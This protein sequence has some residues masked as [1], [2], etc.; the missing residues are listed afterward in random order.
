[1]LKKSI[2]VLSGLYLSLVTT[3]QQPPMADHIPVYPTG[4]FRNP[5]NIPIL[6]AGNFGEC[7][8]N[9]FH[10]GIDIKTGGKENL[11]VF[12]AAEGHVSR[13]RMSKGGFGHALYLD[14]PQGFTTV[15]AHLNDF[16]PTIQDYTIKKQYEQENWDIDI[17]LSPEQF[18]V[19]KGQQIAWSGNT[20]SSQ[21]PHLH[22]EI[23]DSRTEHPL[24]PLLFGL[25]VTDNR[26]PVPLHIAVYDLEQSIYE[27]TPKIYPLIKTGNRYV[28]RDT[29]PAPSG[30]TAIAIHV[31]DYMDG[32][33]NTLNF[34]TAA[35][36]L[37]EESQGQIRLDDIGYEETRYLHA[38]IDY[39]L[40]KQRGQW[41]Q[42]LFQLPGN[43]LHH[44][45]RQLNT[46]N[47]AL[48]LTGRTPAATRILL[49]DAA[50][51]DTEISLVFKKDT[52]QTSAATTC[53][54][55]FRAGVAQT[56]THPNVR[57][58]L[59]AT[60]LYDDVCFRFRAAAD[61]GAY[62]GK[63][64]L[65]HPGV[66]VHGYFNLQLKPEKPVPFALRDKM[67]LT[68]NDGKKTTGKAAVFSDGWYTAAVREFGDYTLTADTLA[69]QIRA[70]FRQGSDLSTA[71]RITFTVTENSTSI[72]SFRAMLNGK[73][74]CFEP[75]GDTFFYIFDAYC[76]KGKHEL[77]I[78]VSDENKNSRTATYTFTR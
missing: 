36:Y 9:H 57:F 66:P 43:Q 49:Y 65:H 41:F 59:S 31:N 50:G 7:R 38:Y 78:T 27:Q 8:P 76:P 12:A 71:N 32:S 35:W 47:G 33:Q 40:R 29:I 25:P 56:F 68:Y 58:T 52:S 20:G 30:K 6:L 18:P 11:P 23:R 1:M 72:A 16:M 62:S 61:S 14:H 64:S 22:F 19:K 48:S 69:P 70:S 15:Y 75:R 3:A 54:Q 4:Y 53:E 2:L 45:Y 13:I 63:Y 60:D 44:I 73:W 26:P 37:N 34:F 51:N 67:V 42:C 55:W 46:L 39:A 5:L 24:N 74:L 77:T 10:S 21:G 28:V 17:T